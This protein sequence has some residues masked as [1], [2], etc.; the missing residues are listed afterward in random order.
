MPWTTGTKRLPFDVEMLRYI[1]L[2]AGHKRR[3]FFDLHR[4]DSGQLKRP[5]FMLPQNISCRLQLRLPRQ[6]L[7]Q[8]H[9]GR[10]RYIG[11]VS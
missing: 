4:N 5:E 6:F 10:Y 7:R 11:R 1:S 9:E 2:N 3:D 8:V